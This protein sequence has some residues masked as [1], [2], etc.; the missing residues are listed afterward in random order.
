MKKIVIP[1]VILAAIAT[2]P[3]ISEV[4]QEL[5]KGGT[6]STTHSVEDMREC[7]LSLS[8]QLRRIG[9]R[10]RELP[11]LERLL[12]LCDASSR[13]HR[14]TTMLGKHPNAML[15]EVHALERDY[16]LSDRFEWGNHFRRLPSTRVLFLASYLEE[17]ALVLGRGAE[18]IKTLDGARLRQAASAIGLDSGDIRAQ[19]AS[20]LPFLEANLPRCALIE[21]PAP[22]MPPREDT[23]GMTRFEVSYGLSI[24]APH[25]LTPFDIASLAADLGRLRAD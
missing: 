5:H 1:I 16:R 9:I 3:F 10:R 14:I 13:L 22:C 24:S 12:H 7:V 2:L 19:A 21:I 15:V 20:E 17:Y 8:A 6:G 18:L 23:A 4:G 11:L 25:T